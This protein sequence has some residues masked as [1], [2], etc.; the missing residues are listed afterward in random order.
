MIYNMKIL[1][2]SY[3]WQGHTRKVA[4]TLSEKLGAEFI[5]IE[6]VKESSMI[7]KVFKALF[8]SKSDIKPVQ[9]DLTDIDHL[10]VA[11]PVWARHTPPYMN[12]YLSLLTNTEG[13]SFSVLVEMK[14]KG[15]DIVIEHISNIL[16]KK[17]MELIITG[18]TLEE[19]VESGKYGDTVTKMAEYIK[20]KI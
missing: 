5:E 7:S 13:R 4:K 19:E 2:V 8:N 10:I 1:V 6:P 16:Q 20:S 11:C 3:S 17:G 12:Q 18:I 9:T 14:S 15:A